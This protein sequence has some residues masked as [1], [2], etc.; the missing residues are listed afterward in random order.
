MTV[1]SK[2]LLSWA[3]FF[4]CGL[5]TGLLAMYVSQNFV[6]LFFG[7]VLVWTVVLR[8]IECPDCGTPIFQTADDFYCR[9][10]MVRVPVEIF[11]KKC[12]VC[13]CDLTKN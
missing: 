11:K 13:G 2:W 7:N 5:V 1:F 3:G 10:R 6:F 12:H 9:P 8:S 4:S